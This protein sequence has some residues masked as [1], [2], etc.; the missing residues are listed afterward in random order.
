MV[1]GLGQGITQDD[2]KVEKQKSER[3]GV[4]LFVWICLCTGMPVSVGAWLWDA[5]GCEVLFLSV[6]LVTWPPVFYSPEIRI[7][8]S[9]TIAMTG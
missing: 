4:V 9:R 2:T 6:R 7:H 1:G 3:F 8:S 5:C